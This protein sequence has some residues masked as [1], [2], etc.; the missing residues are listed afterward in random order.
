MNSDKVFYIKSE[1]NE[2][3]DKLKRKMK[4]IG[5]ISY[6]T[7]ISALEDPTIYA[8]AAS[9]GLY[10]GLKYNGSFKRGIKGGLGTAG[11]YIGVNI[12]RNIVVNRDV[13]K[14]T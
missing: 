13:I 1:K 8:S 9:I 3:G 5:E 12:V 7:I 2:M 10:Q 11:V 4:V 6:Q 14:N